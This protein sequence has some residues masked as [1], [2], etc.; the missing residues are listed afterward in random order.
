LW[1]RTYGGTGID[2]GFAVVQTFD[3]GYI[4]SGYTTSYGA[5]DWDFYLVRTDDL[6]ESLWTA[7]YGGLSTDE[8][9]SITQTNDGG[10]VATGNTG[11]FGAGSRDFYVVRLASDVSL[12]VD[13]STISESTGGVV[14][15]TLNAGTANANRNYLLAGSLSG[16][17]PGTLLPGG[18]VTIPLNR[19]WFTDFI[20]ARLNTIP[21][22]NFWGTLDASGQGSARLNAPPIPGWAGVTMHFA[23][24]TSNPWD[25]ASNAVAIE[26]VP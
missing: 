25:F 21:F 26:I 19:D 14:N 20:L 9:R 12:D 1:T 8:C 15:F 22:T 5:G 17:D 16:T 24:V 2:Q 18:L 4:V 3:G 6:G 7:T 13:V 23:F 11:S 10:F